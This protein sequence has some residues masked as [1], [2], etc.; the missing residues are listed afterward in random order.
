MG[1]WANNALF[2]G[3]VDGTDI[4]LIGYVWFLGERTICTESSKSVG[5][6]RRRFESL[7]RF[8]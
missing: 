6:R 8:T 4:L 5:R 1:F 7:S 3:G 2:T